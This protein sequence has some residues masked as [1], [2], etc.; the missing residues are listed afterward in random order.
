MKRV[1][2]ILALIGAFGF[3]AGASVYLALLWSAGAKVIGWLYAGKY[4]EYASWPLVF[5]ALLPFTSCVSAA[6]GSALR[7]LE[8]PD[9][10]FWCYL[11]AGAATFVVGVPLASRLGVGGALAGLLVSSTIAAAAMLAFSHQL[12]KRV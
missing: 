11:A 10:I 6:V 1:L 7:A 12:L 8:R 2:T 4:D 3:G 9:C 5:A